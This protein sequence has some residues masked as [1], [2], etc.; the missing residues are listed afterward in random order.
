MFNY[1]IF[2]KKELTILVQKIINAL[3]IDTNINII[4][5]FNYIEIF[6]K[7]YNTGTK[8]YTSIVVGKFN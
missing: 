6:Q 8:I 1:N 4:V 2:F 3:S 5:I 7:Y